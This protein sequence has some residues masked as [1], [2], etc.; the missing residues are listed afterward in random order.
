MLQGFVVLVGL[1]EIFNH[2]DLTAGLGRQQVVT[3]VGLAEGGA[4]QLGVGLEAGGAVV[5][6]RQVEVELLLGGDFA[7]LGGG[8]LCA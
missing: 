6:G 1:D 3:T 8:Y 2:R 5:L 7:G 4:H